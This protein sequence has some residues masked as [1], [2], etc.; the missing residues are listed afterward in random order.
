VSLVKEIDDEGK[1]GFIIAGILTATDKFIDKEYSNKLKEWLKMTKVGR[2]FEEEK[3]EAI[4]E[5]KTKDRKKTAY[6][7]FLNREKIKRI[8]EYSELPDEDLASV[9]REMPSEIQ[10]RYTML[11][12]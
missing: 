9:L 12:V 2:L 7:M 10:A 3:I 6:K 1:Q 11:N 4:K 8:R 5:E